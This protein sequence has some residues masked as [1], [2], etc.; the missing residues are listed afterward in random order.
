LRPLNGRPELRVAFWLQARVCGLSLQPIGCMLAMY[1]TQ[2]ASA[3]AMR[4]LPFATAGHTISWSVS[5][6]VRHCCSR[7]ELTGTC[8]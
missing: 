6:V 3:A 7:R 2:S 5:S 1:V 4:G 8:E